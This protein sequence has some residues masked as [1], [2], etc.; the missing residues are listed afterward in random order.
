VS[1][2][3]TKSNLLGRKK[4]PNKKGQMEKAENGQ[5]KKWLNEKGRNGQ[6]KRPNIA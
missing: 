4:W 6:R 5:M 2:D 1:N 3:P